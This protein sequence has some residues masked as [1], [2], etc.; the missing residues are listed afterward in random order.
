MSKYIP[1]LLLGIALSISCSKSNSSSIKQ[2]PG[3]LPPYVQSLTDSRD[4]Y[5]YAGKAGSAYS[6]KYSIEI[7][8][9]GEPIYFQNTSRFPFHA[10]FL[11]AALPKYENLSFEQYVS[12]V[13]GG[14]TAEGKQLSAGSLLFSETFQ[15]ARDLPNGAMAFE[16]YMGSPDKALTADVVLNNLELIARTHARLSENIAFMKGRIALLLPVNLRFNNQ[17]LIQGLKAKNIPVLWDTAKLRAEFYGSGDVVAYHP[18][19]SYGYLKSMSLEDMAAERY[20]SKDI[21]VLSDIPLDIGPVSG[22]ISTVPQVPLAHIMLRA[23]NQNVPDLFVL[24]ALENPEIKA[25]LGK[26]V[27]LTVTSDNKFSIQSAEEL[28]EI[29][30]LAADYFKNRVK[31]LPSP[32]ADLSV[33]TLLRWNTATLPEQAVRVYGAKGSNFAQLDLALQ[34]NGVNR[35]LYKGA[36]LIPF[37]AYDKHVKA[38]LK[39]S[40]CDKAAKE[41]AEDLGLS[42]D[43]VKPLCL[44]QSQKTATIAQYIA[45]STQDA[46]AMNEAVTRRKRLAMIRGVIEKAELDLELAQN[47]KELIL[48]NYPANVRFRF[49][50]STNAEDL[51]GLNGAGLYESKSG[52]IQ[53]DL[54]KAAGVGAGQASA[55]RTALELQRMNER[56]KALDPSKDAAAIAELQ[57]DLTKKDPLANGIRKVFASLWTDRAFIT[58]DYYGMDHFK[59]FMGIL[60]IPSFVDEM[61]NGVLSIAEDQ[62]SGLFV[63][64]SCQ[65][66]D[67]SI[68]NPALRGA[69]PENFTVT[70]LSDGSL[71][72][73]SYLRRSN[74]IA[75][76]VLSNAQIESLS[77][78]AAIVHETQKASLGSRY[79]GKTDI[80]FIVDA[81]GQVLIK[82]ARPFPK[83]EQFS[84]QGD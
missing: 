67:I 47:V 63:N 18:Q 75:G 51:P 20:S 22:L 24:G 59:V 2:T 66:E 64:V 27:R 73:L 54:D 60:A 6:L 69:I 16:Y 78:Q 39:S 72:K 40:V 23:I 65:K 82:Q 61:A 62:S 79:T 50:S 84:S 28:P 80:E 13:F 43:D 49:R 57:K 33:A 44:E 10:E 19:V 71:N 53:D 1:F 48:A 52:C 35:Q 4:Y 14:E 42:C 81:A 9:P 56:L 41:C 38:P 70:R 32:E 8:E 77:S 45:A 29:E 26:L 15:L 34:K 3:E 36:F 46:G 74:L 83:T 17:A 76:Q 21:L 58:R 7:H 55:C 68:T 12:Y 5:A 11:K 31:A 30:K 37:S 25:K